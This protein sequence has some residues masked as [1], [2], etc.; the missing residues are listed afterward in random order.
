MAKAIVRDRRQITLPADIC[1][2]LGLDV[3]DAVELEVENGALRVTPSRKRALDALAAI[4]KA[5][6]ESGVTE[7][8]FLAEGR[9]VRRELVEERYG[10]LRKT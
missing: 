2:Q 10:H 9:R 7:K 5:F 3:G 8:E 6:Q 1:K 4:Q